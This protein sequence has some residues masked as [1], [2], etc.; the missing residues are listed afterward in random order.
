[1]SQASDKSQSYK[2]Q[3]AKELAAELVKQTEKISQQSA[4]KMTVNDILKEDKHE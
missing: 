1:M 4:E 2:S 3:R